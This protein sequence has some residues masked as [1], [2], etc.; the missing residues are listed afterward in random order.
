MESAEITCFIC[1]GPIGS[2]Q[3]FTQCPRCCSMVFHRNC[4]RGREFKCPCNR[5]TYSDGEWNGS[6]I[7]PPPAT[8]LARVEMLN[9]L[10]S[11]LIVAVLVSGIAF[12]VGEQCGVPPHFYDTTVQALVDLNTTIP[13]HCSNSDLLSVQSALNGVQFLLKVASHGKNCTRLDSM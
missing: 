10:I 2:S 1:L 13:V 12:R 8:F 11:A 7:S 3:L 5:N 4:M 6:R 9:M